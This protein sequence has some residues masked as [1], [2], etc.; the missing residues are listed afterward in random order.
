MTPHNPYI[1]KYDR[2]NLIPFALK[3]SQLLQYVTPSV[4]LV[5]ESSL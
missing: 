4:F 1:E 2:F 3:L 5:A